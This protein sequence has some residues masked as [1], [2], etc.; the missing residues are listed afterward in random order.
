[1][2]MAIDLLHSWEFNFY[3]K[4]NSL[5]NQFIV[6]CMCN[7]HDCML[8]RAQNINSMRMATSVIE[9]ERENMILK[10]FSYIRV[11]KSLILSN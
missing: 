5:K 9:I 10:L 11:S 8:F 2:R 7:N 1:M 3:L 4:Q 6:V